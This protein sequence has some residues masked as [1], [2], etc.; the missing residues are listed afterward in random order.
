MPI[1]LQSNSMVTCPPEDYAPAGSDKWFT[2]PNGKDKGKKLFYYDHQTG[3]GE[4]EKT[5]L[6][7]HGN[8]ATSYTFR[9]IRDA[10]IASGR[11]L[12]LV[13]MDHIGF[14]LSDNADYWVVDMHHA[15][16]LR[17]LVQHLDVHNICLVL[18]D[19]GGPI[20]AG[21]LLEEPDRVNQ[22]AVMNTTIFP[23]PDDGYTYENYPISWFPWCKT[24]NYV[25]D[26]FW[27]G[28]PGYVVCHAVP[29]PTMRFLWNNT[30]SMLRFAG[31]GFEP[32]TA[33]YVWSE[34]FKVN[35]NVK[36]SKNFVRQTRKMGHGA[37]YDDPVHGRQDSCT[38]YRNMQEKI[39]QYWGRDGRNIPACG[40]FG[41]W[42]ALG[43]DSVIAQWCDALPRLSGHI[44]EYP[45]IG[46]FVEEFKGE[47][48]AQGILDLDV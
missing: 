42:D 6:F 31:K 40:F 48:I 11:N 24:P 17:Q 39:V 41:K 2:I 32:G 9:H 8:P 29:Q 4:P 35:A 20:G 34:G 13:A 45:D 46:H 26:K 10:L 36:A 3:T 47:D 7:V 12:R 1:A 5:V 16:N 37:V 33:D 21:A 43:K 19:W 38:F 27:G 28:V 22:I 25:M 14:G 23:M 44:T 18:H 30:K 15:D